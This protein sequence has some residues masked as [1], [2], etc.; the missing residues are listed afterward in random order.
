[1]GTDASP[2]WDELLAMR[3]WM[4]TGGFYASLHES[5]TT[6]VKWPL[7]RHSEG[8][9]GL[10]GT[11][12]I[13]FTYDLSKAALTTLYL[14]LLSSSRTVTAACSANLIR[15]LFEVLFR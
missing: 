12:A 4:Q 8:R 3:I 5:D 13:P 1:M 2:F 7:D 9:F 11:T 6:L 15:N 14:Q 10:E